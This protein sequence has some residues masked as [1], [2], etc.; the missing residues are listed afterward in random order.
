MRTPQPGIEPGSQPRQG[1][2]LAIGLLRHVKYS[3]RILFLKL[4]IYLFRED[5]FLFSGLNS[6][7]FTPLRISLF[8]ESSS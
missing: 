6:K 8:L 1:R 2:V 5:F 4:A 7:T 3:K